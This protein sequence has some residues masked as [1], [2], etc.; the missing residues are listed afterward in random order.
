[1][2]GFYSRSRGLSFSDGSVKIPKIS[3]VLVI[4]EK[5]GKALRKDRFQTQDYS[6]QAN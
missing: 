3:G 1:M 5:N 4:D 6:C 2:L